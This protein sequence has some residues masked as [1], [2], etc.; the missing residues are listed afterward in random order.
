MMAPVRTACYARFSSDLQRETSLEDQ[1]RSC[2]E[3][4][5]QH[6]FG[7]Q[8]N[9]IFT[10]AAI[11]GA[12]LDGRAGLQALLTAA[13]SRAK[14]FDVLLVDD[15]S[16]V[17]RD[18]ADALRVI[19]LLKFAGV[20]VIYISQAIDSASE[21]AETLVAVHGLIDSVFLR[22][23]ATKIRRG[24]I[25]QLER[26]Y[27]TGGLHYGYRSITIPDP[28][29]QLDS[30]GHPRRLGVQ[31]EIHED[32]AAIIRRIFTLY[33]D[34]FGVS[35]IVDQLNR[36]STGR[37]WKYTAVRRVL[38][39]ERYLGRQIFGK[40]RHE[41]VPGS[42]NK[43]QRT[44]PRDEWRVMERPELRIVS[45]DL[46]ARVVQHNQR[47]R[48]YY[49]YQ[50]SR[51]LLRGRPG[52]SSRHLFSGFLRCGICEGT[53]VIV[54]TGHGSPRYGCLRRSKEGASA[55]TNGLTI[56]AKIAE[57]AL[58]AGLQ[59]ELR[60][61]ETLAY[62]TERLATELNGVM[63]TRPARREA[64]E[65]TRRDAREKL[66]NLVA[67]IEAGAGSPTM[68]Q[69]IR[70]REAELGALEQHLATLDEPLSDRLAVIPT[71]VREQLSDAA[72]LLGESPERA[73]MEFQRLGI[74]F[75]VHP[76]YDEGRRPFLRAEG[77]GNFAHL[78]FSKYASRV[79]TSDQSDRR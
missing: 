1:I 77:H 47:A 2:R 20:R 48:E 7:W 6:G 76:V 62:I 42:R 15:S 45:D 57:P 31:L 8:D 27:S 3:Y 52:N 9:Q 55:C 18:L 24:L 29:G 10:D 25:G 46:W 34:G 50:P 33:A 70:D 39:N 17:A 67:A 78:A 28:S 59:A 72:A 26:G 66:R 11:S 54:H 63:D 64:L 32:E 4:A 40:H 16:R 74:R 5:A 68:F 73:K 71:W 35:R 38:S 30:H 51:S 60:R 79:P 13:A 43:V 69:A 21:Q 41:R 65:V 49:R 75:V 14:P 12:S 58:V 53:V 61:P 19:Q 37:R 56:R 22:E 44:R 36:D 23:M